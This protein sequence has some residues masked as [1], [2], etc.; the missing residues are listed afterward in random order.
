MKYQR[1]PICEASA[2]QR[3]FS[4]VCV[5]EIDCPRCGR[6][7]I[8][9]PALHDLSRAKWSNEQIANVSSYLRRN[10]DS[11]VTPEDLPRLAALPTP[12]VDEK[13]A[14]LLLEIA[15]EN[16]RPGTNISPPVFDLGFVKQMD[17]AIGVM[18]EPSRLGAETSLSRQLHWLG[19]AAAANVE[20]L[21][22]LTFNCL[23]AQGY[24]ERGQSDGDIRVTPLGWKEI[25]QLKRVNRASRAG[26][27]AMSFW[28]QYM[29]LFDFGIAPAITAAGYEP[30][31]VD[32]YEHNNRIDDEIIALIKQSR[33][34]VTD[35]TENRGGI[36]FE[37]GLALGLG[38]PVIWLVRNDR[39]DEVHFDNRQ[40]NFITWEE[41]AWDDLA[42]RLRYRIEATIG[43]GINAG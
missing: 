5:F 20:E 43:R 42:R 15:R 7:R 11:L 1:C 34:V 22:W 41:G 8:D 6:F 36:Y 26:F 12:P 32:R 10:G 4:E 19:I 39:M 24:L 25:E 16:P 14:W 28:E 30:R 31:R 3:E 27:V 35:L 29:S 23:S 33:F 2:G 17:E 13:A 38:L 40:Y 18:V 21:Y 9:R 37:A